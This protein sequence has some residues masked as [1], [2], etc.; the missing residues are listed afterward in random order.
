MAPRLRYRVLPTLLN[1]VPFATHG[2]IGAPPGPPLPYFVS[3]WTRCVRHRGQYF[4]SS[5]RLGSFRRFFSVVYV[6]SLHSLHC[7][8]I[9]GRMSFR[10][11]A[12]ATPCLSMPGSWSRHPHRR[13]ARLHGWQTSTP[14]PAPP[15]RSTPPS[16][17]HHPPASPS[18]PPPAA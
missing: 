7:S 4:F 12:I 17:S 13:S 2:R 5:K 9:T 8:V 3:R 14:V 6:R 11:D 10:F 18:P 16:G 1:Q 15:A